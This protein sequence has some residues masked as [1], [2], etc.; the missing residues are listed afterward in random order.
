M[1]T[2]KNLFTTLLLL[3]ATVATAHDFKVDGIYYNLNDASMTA[4]VTYKGASYATEE[5]YSGVVHVPSNIV[6]NGK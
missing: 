6:Y 3:C 2:F 1:K 5:E 4:E